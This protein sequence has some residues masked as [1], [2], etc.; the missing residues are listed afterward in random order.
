MSPAVDRTI[1]KR[2]ERVKGQE[3]LEISLRKLSITWV[4]S[5]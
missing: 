5:L 1:L 4:G 3:E 2:V